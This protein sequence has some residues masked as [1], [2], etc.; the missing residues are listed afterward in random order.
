MDEKNQIQSQS[1]I[2]VMKVLDKKKNKKK[3]IFG[4][5]INENFI[6]INKFIGQQKEKASLE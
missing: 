6:S 4:E 1:Y 5:K 3:N 2:V